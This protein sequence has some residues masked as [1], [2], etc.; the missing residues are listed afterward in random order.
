MIDVDAVTRFQA[1]RKRSRECK[2]NLRLFFFLFVTKTSL[3]NERFWHTFQDGLKRRKM[4]VFVCQNPSRN[5]SAKT[6]AVLGF[7]TFSE[8]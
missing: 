2:K 7:E 6:C 8:F 4:A 3:K 5:Q 1:K